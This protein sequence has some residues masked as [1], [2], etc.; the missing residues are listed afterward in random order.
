MPNFLEEKCNLF[1]SKFTFVYLQSNR[2]FLMAFCYVLAY[3]RGFHIYCRSHFGL[4]FIMSAKLRLINIDFLLVQVMYSYV[5][6]TF[7]LSCPWY[8]NAALD[9]RKK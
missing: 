9:H 1:L 8:L 4:Q 7:V 2:L 3:L 6:Y 5:S